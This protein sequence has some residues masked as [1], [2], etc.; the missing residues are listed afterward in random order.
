MSHDSS[1]YNQQNKFFGETHGEFAV[2][3]DFLSLHSTCVDVFVLVSG[4]SVS[5]FNASS[6][7]RDFPSLLTPGFATP[8]PSDNSWP[9]QQLSDKKV[10]I[11]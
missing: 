5:L 3:N 8:P 10:G 4:L 11:L 7:W 1:N 6:S 2:T 9:Q